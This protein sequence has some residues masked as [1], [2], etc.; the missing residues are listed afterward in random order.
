VRI[1]L[2]AFVCL[3]GVSSTVVA[4][5][6]VEPF[7]EA[8]QAAPFNEIDKHVLGALRAQGV[9]P[10][11]LSSDAVFVRRVYL[12]VIGKLPTPAEVRRFMADRASDKRARLIDA[13]LDRPEFAEYWAM[14]WSDLL[15]VKAEHP[16]NLWPNGVQAYYRWIHHSLASNKPYDQF[17]RELL[18]SSGSNF[19]VP[20][21]NFYR[22][23]QGESPSAITAAVALTFMGSRIED[24]PADRRARMEV[25]FSHVRYKP[26]SEWK[27][28]I[29]LADPEPR[30]TFLGVL[31][32][33]KR[34]TIHPTDDPRVVFADWLIQPDNDAFTAPIA[35]RVWTWLVGRGIVQPADD[36]AADNPPSHPKL[37]TYLQAELVRS[38][39]DL[40]HL[41]RLILNSRTY[42]QSSIPQGGNAKAGEQFAAYTV[43]PLEAEVLI[44][45]LVTLLGSPDE[46]QSEIP[47]PFTFVPASQPTV[48]LSDGSITSPFLELFG[49]PSRDTGLLAERSDKPTDRQ[50]LHRLNSTHV[51]KKIERSWRVKAM[52]RQAHRDRVKMV[53]DLY[54]YILSRRPTDAELGAISDYVKKHNPRQAAHDLVWSLINSKEFLY[55]H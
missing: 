49:R 27:E 20:A 51:Q 19:R 12:D 10:A 4:A 15:R 43:R 45:A 37:L 36:F 16:I 41:Y 31:P 32:D 47:E 30:D 26:T 46:Y 55:R 24:W 5:P 18:T 53:T 11:H 52:T 22:A 23:I 33:G 9:K 3:I 38:K 50:A 48:A 1:A 2:L 35:N 40:K 29:I 34:V 6:P 44:D 28:Q 17:A 54:V 13:L 21:V 8:G 39:Y 42:Q 25:F 7:E 14:K